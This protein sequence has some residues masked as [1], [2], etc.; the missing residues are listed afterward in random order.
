MAVKKTIE[1]TAEN[2]MELFSRAK[3]ANEI[4]QLPTDQLNRLMELAK[5][6]KA[7]GYLESEAK[8]FTLKVLLK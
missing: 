1:I 4:L 2:D 7:K 5:I 3:A 6:P 8:F